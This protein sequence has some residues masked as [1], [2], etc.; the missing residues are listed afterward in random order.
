[1]ARPVQ[2]SMAV[3][4]GKHTP[5][6]SREA[7][8]RGMGIAPGGRPGLGLT[9]VDG[10]TAAA[11]AGRSR[12][13]AGKA[14]PIGVNGGVSL[15]EVLVPCLQDRGTVF[16]QVGSLIRLNDLAPRNMGEA[17][18]R[19]LRRDS[20][21]GHPRPRARPE[22][23]AASRRPRRAG[24]PATAPSPAAARRSSKGT[25]AETRRTACAPARA[26]RA[27]SL[28]FTNNP[29]LSGALPARL[30]DLRRLERLLA[31]GTDLCA[32]QD[33]G[34]QAWLQ[35][36]HKWWIS[37]CASTSASMVYLTQ[38][39]QS[40]EYPVPL[41]AGDKALLRVFVT[42]AHAT[43][44]GIPPVRAR[45]YLNGTERHVAEIPANAAPIPT[46]VVEGSLSGSANAEIP[47]EIVRPGL[48][49]VIEIDPDGSLV[50]CSQ[51]LFRFADLGDDGLCRGDP[52][53][54]CG[55]IVSAIDVVVDRLD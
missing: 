25:P 46:E 15:P 22:S 17:G 54:G 18:L 49:M 38:A 9:A 55:V 4:S 14:V 35:T 39:V 11:P 44:A 34:F 31:G 42:A 20:G 33:S 8:S 40:R 12:Y 30:T 5:R 19:D 53:K 48:E 24:A 51:S 7:P 47:G 28:S 36:V 13:G 16:Q 50:L 3:D 23:V 6:R 29:G 37:S 10:T 26:R 52:D 41:V 45:F 43:M 21:F 27:R 1:M 2:L 32:P